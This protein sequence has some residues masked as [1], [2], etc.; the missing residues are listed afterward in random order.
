[1]DLTVAI[2]VNEISQLNKR[3]HHANDQL[4]EIAHTDSLTQVWNR[5]RIEQAIDAELSAAERYD[6]PCSILLFDVDHF[7]HVND[8]HGHEVGDIVL[9]RLTS[10]VEKQLRATDFLG[11]WGGEEFIVLASN[12][13]LEE[14]GNLAERLRKHIASINFTDVGK[15]TISIGVAQWRTGE[16]RRYM[17]ERAD[18]AMYQA[19]QS[20]R[21]RVE[22]SE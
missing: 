13:M 16:S 15:V 12:N 9:K 14:A 18:K 10:E 4:K 7:K 11:R 6:R 21:N 3:L 22:L 20:G 2:N 5:Y 17:L 1:E 8:E 19:K